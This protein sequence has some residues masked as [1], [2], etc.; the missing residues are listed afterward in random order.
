MKLIIDSNSQNEA[1]ARTVVAAYI[2]RKDSS[3]RSSHQ[4]HSPWI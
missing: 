3:I 1:F 4:Q 2:T